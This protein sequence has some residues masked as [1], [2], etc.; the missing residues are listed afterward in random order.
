[1][2]TNKG[3]TLVELLVV[4]AILGILMGVAVPSYSSYLERA[5]QTKVKLDIAVLEQALELFHL[6]TGR[7]P[8]PS[9]GLNA[10]VHSSNNPQW[11]GPYLKQMPLDPSGQAYRYQVADNRPQ[12]TSSLS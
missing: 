11:M 9:E 6:D 2:R 7:Y 10:L 5:K 3:F 4:L 1:M 8:S 12:I